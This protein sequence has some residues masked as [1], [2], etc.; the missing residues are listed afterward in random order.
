MASFS[1]FIFSCVYPAM[2]A[3]PTWDAFGGGLVVFAY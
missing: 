1:H 2:D 3:T